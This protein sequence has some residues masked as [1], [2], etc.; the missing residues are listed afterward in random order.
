VSGHAVSVTL[1]W[2]AGA[3]LFAVAAGI[4]LART[5]AAARAQAAS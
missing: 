4:S 2:L 1:A 3:M 5:V